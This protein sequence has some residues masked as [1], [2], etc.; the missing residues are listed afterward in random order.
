[1]NIILFLL[2][3]LIDGLLNTNLVILICI[4]Y[5][6]NIFK[7]N[8]KYYLSLG[9]IGLLIDIIFT[10]T[11]LLNTIIFP[12][13]GYITKKVYSKYKES[14]IVNLVFMISILF[15]YKLSTMMI[16]TLLEDTNYISINVIKT[17]FDINTII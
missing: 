3:I 7:H 12:I 11:I 5:T 9:L 16:L 10:E 17:L 6:N 1:M 2:A 4:L 15:L 13:I 14:I 8:I